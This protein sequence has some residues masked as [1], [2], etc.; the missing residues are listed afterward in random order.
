MVFSVSYTYSYASQSPA[1]PMAPSHPPAAA[2]ARALALLSGGI[3]S[4]VALWWAKAQ[5]WLLQ[6]IAFHYPGRPALE[7]EAMSRVAEAAG[8]APPLAIGVPVLR[9]TGSPQ[10]AWVSGN[11]NGLPAGYI[12]HRNLVYY[13]L[14]LVVA[15]HEG[16]RWIVGGHLKTDGIEYADARAPYFEGLNALAAQGT[17]PALG[18]PPQIVLPLAGMTKEDCLREAVRLGVRLDLT[19]SCYLDGVAHCGTCAGCVDRR[20]GFRNTGIEDRTPYAAPMP[21]GPR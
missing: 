8:L 19:W 4:A 12:P 18:A 10:Y 7:V 17:P 11:G 1:H 20:I 21:A 6:P 16:A 2:P 15:A 3:D 13:S 14:A 5:G 9:M